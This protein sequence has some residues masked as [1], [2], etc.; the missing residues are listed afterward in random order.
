VSAIAPSVE[1]VRGTAGNLLEAAITQN[2]R[3]NV[4]ALAERSDIIRDAAQTGKLRIVGGVYH[5][6]TG[7][8]EFLA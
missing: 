2:V 5:L 1:K 7:R 4:A 8:V 6:A 3:D